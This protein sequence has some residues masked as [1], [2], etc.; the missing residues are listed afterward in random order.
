MKGRWKGL[1]AL[2]MA[3]ALAVY[4]FPTTVIA[5]DSI[6]QTEETEKNADGEATPYLQEMGNES[7]MTEKP[8]VAETVE[9]SYSAEISEVEN[10]ESTKVAE[11]TETVDGSTAESEST[12][13]TVTQEETTGAEET[14]GE[15][16]SEEETVKSTDEMGESSGDETDKSEE[17]ESGETAESAETET[18]IAEELVK[19]DILEP[20]VKENL[21]LKAAAERTGETSVTVWLY[22][23]SIEL[24]TTIDQNDTTI[25]KYI[26]VEFNKPFSE[27][28][29]VN[30][31]GKKLSGWNLWQVSSGGAVN[32]S[33][34]SKAINDELSESDYDSF[35]ID[36]DNYF[37]LFSPIWIDVIEAGKP[38]NMEAG[39]EYVLPAGPWTVNED[40]T[41]YTGDYSIYVLKNG[42]YTF[43][44]QE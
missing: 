33:F 23:G 11:S 6:G 26:P 5:E 44:K 18:N 32:R 17:E 14:E 34:G 21:A 42:T 30:L 22:P 24:N 37:L 4:A 35:T 31:S 29:S 43:R 28:L 19:K 40:T 1:C 38:L 41:I 10:G 25:Q 7:G 15:T 27:W 36:P 20:I 16:L 2:W 3:L 9:S 12:E 13:E 39:K 8:S